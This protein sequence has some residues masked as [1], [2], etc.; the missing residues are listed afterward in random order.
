MTS[1]VVLEEAQIAIVLTP[2]NE[3]QIEFKLFRD[4]VEGKEPCEEL[5]FSTGVALGM[6][7][8]AMN[9]PDLVAFMF[10]HG[11]EEP[12]EE[13]QKPTLKLVTS[14][15]EPVDRKPHARV[16][17]ND[18]KSKGTPQDKLPPGAGGYTRDLAGPTEDPP[19][20]VA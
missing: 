10:K 4:L 2:L 13:P 19:D 5:Y 8:V 18:A 14:E 17:A 9:S 16:H 3:G 20:A 11:Q 12:I 1:P 15:G 7:G 6:I